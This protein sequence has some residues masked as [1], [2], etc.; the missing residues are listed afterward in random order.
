MSFPQPVLDFLRGDQPGKV[1]PV[2]VASWHAEAVKLHIALKTHGLDCV[3]IP[4]NE[5]K[6]PAVKFAGPRDDCC[7]PAEHALDEK[8]W[9]ERA[10]GLGI[11]VYEGAVVLDFD[12]MHNPEGLSNFERCLPF[13]DGAPR[14]VTGGGVHVFFKA[15]DVSRELFPVKV[16]VGAID[17]LTVTGTGTGHNLNMAP[18]GNKR[19]VRGCSLFNLEPPSIP[20]QLV[21]VLVDI[22]AYEHR[23]DVGHD[24]GAPRERGQK[25]KVDGEPVRIVRQANVG[26]AGWLSRGGD[27]IGDALFRLAGLHDTAP[28]RYHDGW[29]SKSNCVCPWGCEEG[30]VHTNNYKTALNKYG[31]LS[32]SYMNKGTMHTPG[33]LV[34]QLDADA[35]KRIQVCTETGIK[36]QRFAPNQRQPPRRRAALLGEA[37]HA[38]HVS[39][40]PAGNLVVP[41]R[42]EF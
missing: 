1:P 42:A 29:Y 11:M 25:R 12:D 16:R 28:A 10:R 18:S 22:Q 41:K 21:D 14:E 4:Q 23:G 34:V 7:W 35:M 3:A 37:S 27:A 20:D 19:W 26:V 36:R 9:R 38:P 31:T 33:S 32:L 15:T 2:Q 30:K 6:A 39:C 24:S 5:H 13:M 8:T 40:V 17:Y